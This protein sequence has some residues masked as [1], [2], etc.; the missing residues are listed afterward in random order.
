L[1]KTDTAAFLVGQ[2][3]HDADRAGQ[4]PIHRSLQ[5]R[6]A[7]AA[8]RMEDVAGHAAAVNAHN[9]YFIARILFPV[10]QHQGLEVGVGTLVGPRL[11]L[12]F[13]TSELDRKDGLCRPIHL[14]LKDVTA[15]DFIELSKRRA[16]AHMRQVLRSCKGD[17]PATPRHK[18]LQRDRA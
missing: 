11:E 12:Q 15:F 4:D 6:I 7:I 18:L 5:L 16:G 17:T 2:V 13:L 8:Q 3:D 9:R 1:T 10:H 14:Q